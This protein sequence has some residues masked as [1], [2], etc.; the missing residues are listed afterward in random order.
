[1]AKDDL[2][3]RLRIPEE[4]KA[5]VAEAAEANNRSMTAEILTRLAMSFPN[6][7]FDRLAR[8]QA[9]KSRER[10]VEEQVRYLTESLADIREQ[11]DRIKKAVD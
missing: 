3:F 4:L 9:L 5:K 6:P 1:M 11:I 10:Q 2:Y 8:A 7:D